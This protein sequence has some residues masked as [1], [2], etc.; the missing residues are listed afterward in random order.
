MLQDLPTPVCT[1]CVGQ[2]VM[3]LCCLAYL[4][5]WGIAFRPEAEGSVVGGRAGLLLLLTFVLAL[6]G[7][8]LNIYGIKE[9]ETVRNTVSIQTIMLTGAVVYI[10]L[11]AATAGIFHRQPTTEL[12][13]IVMWA[14]MEVAAVQAMYAAG[15]FTA[16][17]FMLAAVI[18]LATLIGLVAYMLYYELDS[19]TAYYCGMVPLITDAIAMCVVV[20]YI[21][22]RV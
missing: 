2:G 13:L 6:A 14:V 8:L 11:L 19:V 16:Y 21:T 3:V 20:W 5:W 9:L 22:E 4:A 15:A 7:V 1:I 17:P 18:A 12:L 10:L